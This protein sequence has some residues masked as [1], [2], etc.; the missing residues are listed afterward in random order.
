VTL[1]KPFPLLV[2][3]LFFGW[4]Q[5]KQARHSFC[6]N[7]SEQ[8]QS[9]ELNNNFILHFSFSLQGTYPAKLK[10]VLIVTAPLWFKAPFKILRLFVRE[11]LRDRVF[12]VSVPQLSLHIPRDSLPLHLGGTLQFNHSSWL[13]NCFKS[14]TNR[15]DELLTATS[16]VVVVGSS[17]S[18]SG[19]DDEQQQQSPTT[20]TINNNNNNNNNNDDDS[21]TDTL[22]GTTTTTTAPNGT[23]IKQHHEET[24]KTTG[25]ESNG[26]IT[27]IHNN[28]NPPSSES[29]SSS[30]FS[31]DDSLT[32]AN[33][34]A[35][36]KTIEQIVEMVKLRTRKGL[37]KEYGEIRARLPDGTFDHAKLRSNVT[38]NR[39]T[40][41]LCY[42]HSR[43]IL[44][45]HV[46]DDPTSD[47]INANFVDGYKQKNAYISTQGLLIHFIQL[48]VDDMLAAYAI[49]RSTS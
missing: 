39:Y 40:D 10:K 43:V 3:P 44:S 38:K 34:V 8:Q 18:A 37:I 36:P 21:G 49:C 15:E 30:G 24:T 5:S 20:T 27:E 9:E 17:S 6:S 13:Q 16:V 46:A 19:Q 29:P 47:Y 25:G 7:F 22:N 48:S 23:N 45:P 41:V 28:W 42:D 26:I 4:R 2:A 14:M 11:K 35:E 1:W 12:T 31:D 33:D 32:G